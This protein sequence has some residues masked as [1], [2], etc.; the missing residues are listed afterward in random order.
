M[1]LRQ[2][3][4]KNWLDRLADGGSIE[5]LDAAQLKNQE[6]GQ[7]KKKQKKSYFNWNDELEFAFVHAV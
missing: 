1:E 6:N 3:I 4:Q 2:V 5:G 7:P